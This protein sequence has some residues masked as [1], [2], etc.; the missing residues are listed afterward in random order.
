MQ[1]RGF[2][3]ALK[4]DGSPDHFRKRTSDAILAM[5]QETRTSCDGDEA[6]AESEVKNQTQPPTARRLLSNPT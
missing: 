1:F 6:M 3:F 2:T 5:I 4:P